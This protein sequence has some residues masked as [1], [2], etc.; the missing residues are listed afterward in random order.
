MNRG[1]EHNLILRITAF[2][3]FLVSLIMMLISKRSSV[4]VSISLGEYGTTFQ[5]RFNDYKPFRYVVAVNIIACAYSVIRIIEELTGLS[6]RFYFY[7]SLIFD[8]LMAYIV[9]SSASAGVGCII[10]T[11]ELFDGGDIDDE[12][13]RK[14]VK[15][16]SASVSI[17]LMGFLVIA[18][19]AVISGSPVIRLYKLLIVWVPRRSVLPIVIFSSKAVL[20]R[21][22]FVLT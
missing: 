13:V 15:Y 14:F 17:Q 22:N 18:G 12:G 5:Y 2:L 20:G 11:K 19:C 16:A 4:T 7:L 1:E 8:Q 3:L 6:G 9:L 10:L 21:D